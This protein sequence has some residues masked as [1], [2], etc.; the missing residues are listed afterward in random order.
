MIWSDW[1][2]FHSED[3]WHREQA[4][5]V[6]EGTSAMF[7]RHLNRYA[8]RNVIKEYGTNASRWD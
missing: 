8:D 2:V 1:Q 5:G 7:T 6:A 3:G 4:E